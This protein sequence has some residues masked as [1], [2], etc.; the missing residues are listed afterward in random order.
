[1]SG[2]SK[3]SKIK[4]EKGFKDR[5]KSN[6]F[7]KLS[8]IITSA[9]VEGGGVID[10]NSNIKL[11]IAE[12]K[13]KKLNMP[14]DNIQRAIEKGIGP[15]KNLL[16]E[17]TYEAFGPGGIAL[18][19]L[20]STDNLNRT[21]SELR[22]VLELH[23]GKLG[24]KGSVM[25]LFRECGLLILKSSE[26]TEEMVLSFGDR[27]GAFDIDKTDDYFKVFIPYEALHNVKDHLNTMHADS[28]E[29]DFKPQI[30]ITI[31]NKEVAKKITGLIEALE[32]LD[33]IHQVYSN[34]NFTS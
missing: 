30:K 11:R 14:K 18:I 2:H 23:R 25:Y 19:I 8:R 16:K 22:N 20:A 21:L 9:V 4:R 1:M 24:N 12:E 6:I 10:P 32:N 15:D 27:I 3:W 33:D 26:T 17:V 34:F 5:E 7:S 31:E 29:I 13:A 28:I